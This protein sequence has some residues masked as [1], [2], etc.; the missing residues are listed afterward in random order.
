[1]EVAIRRAD[2]STRDADPFL[3]EQRLPLHIALAAFTKGSASVNHDDEAGSIEAGNRA[4]LIVLDRN[5][6]EAPGGALA[7]A[8]VEH[9]IAAGRVVHSGP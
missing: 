1:M 3:P 5:L 2:P 6:F 9:T 4:D 8:R 7:E